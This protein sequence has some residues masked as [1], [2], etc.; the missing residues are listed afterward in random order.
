MSED[1]GQQTTEISLRD[2]IDLLRR[3]KYVVIQTFVLVLMVGT[4]VTFMTKPTY[5]TG[6]RILVEGREFTVAQYNTSDPLSNLFMP[7]AGHDIATQI[8]VLQ[9]DKVM[10][11]AFQSA[12]VSPLDVRVD[13]KQIGSTDVIEIL[14]E[15]NKAE[16]AERMAKVLPTTYLKYMTGNRKNEIL[17]ALTSSRPG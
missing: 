1:L 2:Y 7:D 13:I 15:S 9:S 16:N 8:E 12:G 6:A 3:R 11:E 10:S 17:N 14:A 5:R 4:I